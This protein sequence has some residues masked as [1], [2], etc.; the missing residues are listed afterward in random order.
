[1]EIREIVVLSQNVTLVYD[2]LDLKG[3]DTTQLKSLIQVE[4]GP[5]VW[6]TPDLIVVVYPPSATVLRL[7]EQRMTVTL[8]QQ[9]GRVG[10]EPMWD[11]I[12]KSHGLVTALGSKLVAFGLNIDIGFVL[13]DA[14][15]HSLTRRCFLRDAETIQDVLGGELVSFTPKL[16]FTRDERIHS[17]TLEP[18][19]SERLKVSQNV[20]T[21]RPGVEL[22]G[23]PELSA[24]YL[25]EYERLIADVSALLDREL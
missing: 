24:L 14:D 10:Q 2:Q 16:V 21:E 11:V 4:P 1:M 20:H 13:A 18:V 17:L 15:P 19:D 9:G 7:A 12:E 25:S 5:N 22:P 23:K 6:D 8:G 3:I